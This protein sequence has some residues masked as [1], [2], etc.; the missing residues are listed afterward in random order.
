MMI[1]WGRGLALAVVLTASQA[2][3]GDITVGDVWARASAGGAGGVG[4]VFLTITNQGDDDQLV[5]VQSPV[6]SMAE[7]HTHR[8]MNGIMIMRKVDTI[9][10][11]AGQK[12]ELKPGGLHIM[13]M[14]MNT[15]LTD[16]DSFPVTLTFAK[17]GTMTV[18][19]KVGK[20]DAMADHHH[21]EDMHH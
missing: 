18:T 7:L 17:A 3:A 21:G 19:A 2:W 10:V 4:A 1:K 13:L 16:G 6:T 14:N 9:P 20:V 11:A 12:V 8:D 5:A 15:A